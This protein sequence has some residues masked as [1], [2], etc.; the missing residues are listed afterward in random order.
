MSKEPIYDAHPQTL[1]HVGRAALKVGDK[2]TLVGRYNKNIATV[3]KVTP[4]RVTVKGNGASAERVF[5]VTSGREYGTGTS[6]HSD[7]LGT[8][9]NGLQQA[10]AAT[11]SIY[12]LDGTVGDIGTKVRKL[13]SL[14]QGGHVSVDDA[15]NIADKT[16]ALYNLLSTA[17]EGIE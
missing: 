1:G 14:A 6:Y 15:K 13:I 5:M 12:Y 4:T 10:L 17:L 3:T 2:V 11:K 7:R 9:P 16:K 8:V